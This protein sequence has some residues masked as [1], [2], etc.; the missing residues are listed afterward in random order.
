M[1]GETSFGVSGRLV[2]NNLIMY[3]RATQRWWPQVLATSL[4]SP[5][6]SEYTRRTLHDFRMIWT[7]WDRWQTLYPETHV[8]T[9]DTGY[10]RNYDVDPYG[11]Y[12]YPDKSGYYAPESPPLFDSLS[13]SDR[14]A[15]KRIVMG[16]RTSD[17]AVAFLKDALRE[18][19]LMEGMLAGSPVLA[20]Y[21]PRLDTGY[22]YKNPKKESISYRDGQLID[23]AGT[24]HAPDALPL[25][26]IL[27]F[28]AMWFA[29]N[30]FYPE[31]NIYD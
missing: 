22:V 31:T 17:G 24:A 2:N 23:K 27:T 29:W 18:Q 8:F 6:H 15:P 4:P 21:D 11:E 9:R 14:Y 30:G 28:H 10:V 5:W 16:T 1:R 7:T 19:K 25:P 13:E 3:D 26:R 20:V 12:D